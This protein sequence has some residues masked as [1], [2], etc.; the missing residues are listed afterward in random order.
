MFEY[1]SRRGFTTN[2]INKWDIS[3]CIG[4]KIRIQD[5]SFT[6]INIKNHDHYTI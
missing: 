4:I 6:H 3:K 2:S 5:S 1:N